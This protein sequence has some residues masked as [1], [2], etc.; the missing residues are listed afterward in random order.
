MGLTPEFDCSACLNS[1]RRNPVFLIDEAHNLL[2]RSVDMFSNDL[3]LA[4]LKDA[5]AVTANSGHIDTTLNKLISE[6]QR[7]VSENPRRH[8]LGSKA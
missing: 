7:L 8:E 1:Q 6:L 3:R 2:T 4:T 5:Q